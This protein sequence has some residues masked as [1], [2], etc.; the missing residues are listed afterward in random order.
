MYN[1]LGKC[2][3]NYFF[4]PVFCFEWNFI[5]IVFASCSEMVELNK[6][7]KT[8]QLAILPLFKH[9]YPVL[10]LLVV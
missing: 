8:L 5:R 6:S 10:F 3:P 1:S 2:F 4:S 7:N 9:K